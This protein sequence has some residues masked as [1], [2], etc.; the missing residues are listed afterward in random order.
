VF[1]EQADLNEDMKLDFYRDEEKKN[2]D[3]RF[4]LPMKRLNKVYFF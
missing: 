1:F 2:K 4:W 3:N